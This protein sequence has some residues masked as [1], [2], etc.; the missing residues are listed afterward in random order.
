MKQQDHIS[1]PVCYRVPLSSSIH[2]LQSSPLTAVKSVIQYLLH[3]TGLFTSPVNEL[4]YFLRSDRYP[5][6]QLSVAEND[7]RRP[8]NLA[9]L[10][11]AWVGA[12]GTI[13]QSMPKG[14][15][16]YGY[17]TLLVQVARPVS[18]GTISLVDRD[19][20]TPPLV[21][22]NYLGAEEDLLV[23]RK[24]IEYA[25]DI[26]RKMMETGYDIKESLTPEDLSSEKVD[27][28]IRR[29][30]TGAYHLSSTCRMA[31]RE[32]GGVVDQKLRV[33][34]VQGLRVADAS[35]FPKLVGVKP[36]ASIVMV[37]EKCADLILKG[38]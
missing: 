28:F 30:A 23:L 38:Q 8:E 26:G 37:G 4:C 34:G 13:E 1:V 12:W 19:A 29:Y 32:Q 27:E 9:D 25:L 6:A 10:E 24:G 17:N 36:Q 14:E 16:G 11:F 2:V 21:D 31:P 3:G 22:P 5:S 35:I 33:Y 20:R 18:T 7:A 15:K